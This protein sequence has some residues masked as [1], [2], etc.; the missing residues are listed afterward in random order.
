MDV[1]D[2]DDGLA[3]ARVDAD[4]VGTWCRM[5]AASRTG[6]WTSAGGST[7]GRRSAGRC[8][9]HQSSVDASPATQ[10]RVS[11][12]PSGHS[13]TVGAGTGA[14]AGAGAGAGEGSIAAA[15]G[16]RM[17]SASGCDM[18]WARLDSL[19]SEVLFLVRVA[20]VGVC[21]VLGETKGRVRRSSSSQSAA[22]AVLLLRP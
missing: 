10:S 21:V 15:M 2:D 12:P 16:M 4:E 17:A 5:A 18:A 22:P 9:E 19:G 13:T 6:R 11:A 8:R 1:P 20:R 3:G 14:G 7:A